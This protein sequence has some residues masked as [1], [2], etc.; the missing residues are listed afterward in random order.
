M[1][2][3][4]ACGVMNLLWI[5]AVAGLVGIENLAPKGGGHAGT[6]R[7]NDRRGCREIDLG[8]AVLRLVRFEQSDRPGTS[9]VGATP[10]CL[11]SEALRAATNRP[12]P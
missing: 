10:E 11:N 7:S 6:G 4:L 8:F 12:Q 5:A 2:L 1:A 9:V 3:L